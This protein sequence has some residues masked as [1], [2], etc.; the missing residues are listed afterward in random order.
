VKKPCLL[1]GLMVV[2]CLTALL[3]AGCGGDTSSGVQVPYE[4]STAHAEISQAS[5]TDGLESI[6]SFV[7]ICGAE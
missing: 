4:G 6:D 2:S 7:P 3:A 1:V 5:V